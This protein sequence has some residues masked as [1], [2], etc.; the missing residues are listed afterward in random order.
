MTRTNSS[1]N[2]VAESCVKCRKTPVDGLKC[3]KCG[4]FSHN[5]C[6]KYM[7][8]IKYLKDG[9]VI[10]CQDNQQVVKETE[11]TSST[12]NTQE[13]HDESCITNKVTIKYLEE[14][15][16]QK[17][18]II[19]Y[20][21]KTIK[22][23]ET[24]IDLMRK[25][26]PQHFTA[27]EVFPSISIPSIDDQKNLIKKKNTPKTSN[28]KVTNRNAVVPEDGTNPLTGNRTISDKS[29]NAALHRAESLQ[30]CEEIINLER[31]TIPAGIRPRKILTGDNV[32]QENCPF[33]AAS[34]NPNRL[35]HYHVTNLEPGINTEELTKY[36]QNF[37]P[38]AQV[39]KLNSKRPQLY[40]SVKITV[41]DDESAYILKTNI[42]PSH[43][44]LNHFFRSKTFVNHTNQKPN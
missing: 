25:I 42:W 13:T 8:N 9:T 2:N 41:P 23:L 26:E 33:K 21:D 40:S 36:L 43:V 44:V 39:E 18:A 12:F 29:V 11:T 15:I 10:C 3:L 20:Q 1:E 31:K 30:I 38:H 27:S 34:T 24:Q 5:S 22:S 16:K 6:L 14:I 32:N 28:P 35:R 4:S 7:K 19:N 37:A 17:E